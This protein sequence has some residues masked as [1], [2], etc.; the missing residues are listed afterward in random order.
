[1]DT[2]GCGATLI[3]EDVILTAAHCGRTFQMEGSQVSISAYRTTTSEAGAKSRFCK[4]WIPHPLF[5]Y[6]QDPQY[7]YDVAVCKLDRPVQIDQSNA[8]VVL[9]TVDV[10]P[11]AGEELTLLGTGKS[12]VTVD[13]YDFFQEYLKTITVPVLT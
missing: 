10:V 7:D 5:N 12:A 8:V 3:A 4:K 6:T 1:M 11:T 2:Y 13:S 9:E